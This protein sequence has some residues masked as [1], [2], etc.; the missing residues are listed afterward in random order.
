MSDKQELNPRLT[1]IPRDPFSTRG[2]RRAVFS[3]LPCRNAI[4][5]R[6]LG[7]VDRGLDKPVPDKK[8]T[9]STR[10]TCITDGGR[11]NSHPTVRLG[12]RDRGEAHWFFVRQNSLVKEPPTVRV[13]SGVRTETAPVFVYRPA[14]ASWRTEKRASN[15]HLQS[16]RGTASSPL[17]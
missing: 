17:H 8:R 5:K 12:F 4:N 15:S 14:G 2:H 3:F 10:S 9:R 1:S 6:N 11:I 13:Q 16:L 7:I